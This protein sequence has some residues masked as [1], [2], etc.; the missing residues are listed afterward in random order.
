MSTIL[1]RYNKSFLQPVPHTDRGN[2]TTA[3]R[4]H[5]GGNL[6]IFDRN[7]FVEFLLHLV[8]Q[9]AEV[10]A[11]DLP[12]AKLRDLE[13]TDDVLQG[14]RYHKVFLLQTEL[15]PFKELRMK[16]HICLILF[17]RRTWIAFFKNS[18]N[19][20]FCILPTGIS[21]WTTEFFSFQE[22]NYPGLM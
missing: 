12:G 4:E 11:S 14:G 1:T 2:L 5:Q 20:A 16:T 8:R 6:F 15:L 10:C 3:Q 9:F 21:S 7:Y 19:I 22:N 18:L 17:C 13:T